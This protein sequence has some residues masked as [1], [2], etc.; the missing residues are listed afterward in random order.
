M[1]D[2]DLH[3]KIMYQILQD[4]FNSE[5]ASFLAFKGWTACYFF[6]NLDRFSTDL[7]FDLVKSYENIDEKIINILKKY[8]KVKIWKFNIKLSYKENGVNIKIDI[9]RKIWKNN[10]YEINN[11]Y[12]TD[13]LTQD[14][15]T[16]FANKLV[17]LT[18]RNA[19]RDIYD[20]YFFFENN[21][22]INE[23]VIL[24]R[25]WK[26]KKELFKQILTKLEK[27]WNNYKIL[28][29]LWEVLKDEKHKSFVKNDLVKKLI[30]ILQFNIDF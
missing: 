14:K 17:A 9:N 7:D 29:W 25:T 1:L 6:H 11:F 24:E 27:L 16:I 2:K 4:I 18:Q 30:W 20:V 3:R 23:K 22:K 26:T 5:L 28:D 21:F 15:T 19:N 13:I 10:S 8:W 12:W